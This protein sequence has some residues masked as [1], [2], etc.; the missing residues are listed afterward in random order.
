MNPNASY[1]AFFD[2]DLTLISVNSGRIL[3]K[4]A[5]SNKQISK[6]IFIKALYFSLL[7][8]L[9]LKNPLNIIEIMIGWLKGLPEDLL[10]Q[11]SEEVFTS[12]LVNAIR[13]EIINE[14][15]FH[16]ENNAK[17]VIL[18]SSLKSIC[19]HLVNYLKMDDAICTELEVRDGL[20]T[21]RCLGNICFGEEK[22][23]RLIEYCEKND[24]PVSNVFYY[25]DNIS[26]SHVLNLVGHPIC[27]NPD[28]KL[29][30]MAFEKQWLVK[31]WH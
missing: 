14:I 24:V 6:K 21:G 5:F 28:I 25:G 1:I 16:K 7:Y 20:F 13:P 29:T 15:Q 12:T 3:L 31:I 10:K 27:I 11:L 18:S 19:T 30:K 9:K 2:V 23:T 17:V 4:K 8:K 22:V 26:D